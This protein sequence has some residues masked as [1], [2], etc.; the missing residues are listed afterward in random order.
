VQ[1]ANLFIKKR[2]SL[3]LWVANNSAGSELAAMTARGLGAWGGVGFRTSD[4]F[5]LRRKHMKRVIA[6]CMR[7]AGCTSHRATEPPDPNHW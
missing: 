3:K 6:C 7:G 5:E 4:F 1:R 2:G